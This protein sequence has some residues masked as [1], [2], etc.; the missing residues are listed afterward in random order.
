MAWEDGITDFSLP[1]SVNLALIGFHY[2]VL[3]VWDVLPSS[4]EHSFKI[5]Q[6]ILV[7][8][9]FKENAK[10]GHPFSLV[11]YPKFN[12]DIVYLQGNLFFIFFFP[13]S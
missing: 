12:G 4:M 11:S 7:A 13:F 1:R 3:S 9:L 5:P 6:H 2:M 8:D 10:F